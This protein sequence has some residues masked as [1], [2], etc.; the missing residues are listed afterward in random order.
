MSSAAPRGLTS[1]PGRD[2]NPPLVLGVVGVCA[3]LRGLVVAT[4]AMPGRDAGTYA[5]MAR[6]AADGHAGAL[7]DTVFHPLHAALAALTMGL[8]PAAAP[9]D[10]EV[11]ALQLVAALG[12]TLTAGLV[13]LLAARVTGSASVACCAGLFFAVDSASARHVAD[14]L[15]EGLFHATIAAWALANLRARDALGW[16]PIAALCAALAYATR[17]EGGLLLVFGPL[18]LAW[19][20]ARR[21]AIA[22][23]AVG[24]VLGASLPLAYHLTGHPLAL[25]PKT[26]FVWDDGAGGA[27]SGLLHYLEHLAKAPLSLCEGVGLVFAPLAAVGLWIALRGAST[28]S[29][30]RD[31]ALLIA[32]MAAQLLIVP[33]LRSHPRFFSGPMPLLAPLAALGFLHLLHRARDRAHP[34]LCAAALCAISFGVE[35]VRLPIQ[36]NAH[37]AGLRPLGQH[38]AGVIPDGTLLTDLPRFALFAGV[39]PGPPRGRSAAELLAEAAEPRITWVALSPRRSGVTVDHL[40]ALGFDAIAFPEDLDRAAEDLDLL[41]WHR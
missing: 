4:A 23:L 7:F 9:G 35:V 21:P 28:C 40:R 27:S 5:W 17:P 25:S 14:G 33:L 38:F 37:R 24:A 10:G 36:H 18:W 1:R 29:E 11:F 12:D 13:V 39:R 22:S 6:Q 30:R 19:A 8:L 31:L 2:V 20:G 34:R 41:V 26:G 3:L 16:A 32:P 15:T